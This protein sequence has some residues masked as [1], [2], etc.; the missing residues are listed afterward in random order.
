[1]K[2]I[3]INNSCVNKRFKERFS[4]RVE[5]YWGILAEYLTSIDMTG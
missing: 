2:H 1:M 4:D 3:S 5:H